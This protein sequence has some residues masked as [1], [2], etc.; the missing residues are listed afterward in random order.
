LARVLIACGAGPERIVALLLPRSVDIV[1]AQLAV[2]TAG[3]AFVPVD[4]DHP[5]KRIEFMLADADPVLVLTHTEYLDRLPG[6]V[7][8]VVLDDPDWLAQLESTEATAVD[9][10]HRSAPLL[11]AHPAYV[12]YT[13]GSSGRPKAVV[14]TH[15]GLASFA[16]AQTEHVEVG[17]GDRVLQFSSPSFDASVL[18]LCLALPAGAALVVPQPGRLLAERLAEVLEGQLISHALIPPAALAT[19]PVEAASGL[20][21]FRCLIVG[22]EACPAELVARWAPSR[23]MINAY[24]PTESTVV[25]AWSQPLSAGGPVPLG[26]PIAN[27]QLYVLDEALQPVPVGAPG[28]LYIAGVG[29]ARGYLGRPGLTAQRFV[30]NPFAGPGSRMYH[31]GDLVRWTPAG[32]LEFMGRAD[33]QV[34]IR[35]YRIELGEVESALLTHPD[36]AQ[37]VVRLASHEGRPYLLTYLV[38]GGAAASR[39]APTIEELREFA[40][41]LLPDYMLPSAVQVLPALPMTSSGK[42]DRRALPAPEHSPSPT[43]GYLAPSTPMERQLA[44]IWAGV[45][46]A[47]RVGVHDNFFELGGDSILSIQVVSRARQAGL[48]LSSKDIFLHQSIAALAPLVGVL[49]NARALDTGRHQ[50]APVEGPAP[51]A[52]VQRWFFNAYGAL[53]HFTMSTVLELA[54]DFQ[55]N[56]L[57]SALEAIVAHHDALRLRFENLDGQWRQQPRANPTPAMYSSP[58]APTGTGCSASSST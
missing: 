33:E 19:L 50:P 46:G 58:G 15:A 48:R 44:G 20:P 6:D 49:D 32:Q 51:L 29:L 1:V 34:K 4:P 21:A 27:T 24:G 9:D 57:Q 8:T 39:G 16:A 25:A 35:G 31:S 52:P 36:I 53:P 43:A 42:I 7:E 10:A 47:P 56:A 23:R 30:A 3:A 5:G 41:R 12:I 18:E 55:E 54:A 26:T 13:S 37:A 14:V 2:V 22:G 17:P 38:M 45:L 11:L 40:G 28:E